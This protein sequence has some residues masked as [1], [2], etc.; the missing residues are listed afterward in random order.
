M[1]KKIEIATET[2]VVA[3]NEWVE[4]GNFHTAMF[5]GKTPEGVKGC[6]CGRSQSS[7]NAAIRDLC[8]RTNSES[9][10]AFTPLEMVVVRHRQ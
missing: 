6:P 10:T 2:R 8:A 4:G 1:P 9:G 7:V 3:A 5:A